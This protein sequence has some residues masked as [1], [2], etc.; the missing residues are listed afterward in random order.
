[1]KMAA[2]LCNQFFPHCK[3][4]VVSFLLGLETGNVVFKGMVTRE[5]FVTC[6]WNASHNVP[7]ILDW[8]GAAAAQE[9][10]ASRGGGA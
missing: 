10:I 5:L 3:S 7:L 6:P 1:M 4:C 8:V 9:L 2:K